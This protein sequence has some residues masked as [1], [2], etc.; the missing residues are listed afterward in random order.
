M[1]F[2]LKNEL[3]AHSLFFNEQCE[4]ITQVPNQKWVMWANRSVCSPKMSDNEQIA[5]VMHQKWAIEGITRFW[6]V[7]K[8]GSVSKNT[9]YMAGLGT[10]FF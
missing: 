2:I 5:Q 1:L 9:V 10:A 3:F 7:G 6:G 4:Q 8:Y